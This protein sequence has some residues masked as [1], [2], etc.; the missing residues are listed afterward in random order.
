MSD[1]GSFA[2]AEHTPRSNPRTWMP[3]QFGG[4][5]VP[6]N[7]RGTKIKK[8]QLSQSLCRAAGPQSTGRRW[9][10]M[11]TR[12]LNSCFQLSP[13]ATPLERRFQEFMWVSQSMSP[14]WRDIL[15]AS[16][17]SDE[18]AAK[19]LRAGVLALMR[20]FSKLGRSSGR[21]RKRVFRG[22]PRPLHC[23]LSE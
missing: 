12:E 17:S 21:P 7:L 14:A 6:P 3:S 23:V 20:L 8:K 13:S 2:C 5:P 18:F 15:Q 19:S 11:M 4:V 22:L 10:R 1:N 9:I 16:G